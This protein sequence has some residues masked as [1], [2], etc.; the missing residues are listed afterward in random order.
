MRR[1]LCLVALLGPMTPAV[2][3]PKP[4]IAQLP[5]IETFQLDNGLQVAFIAIDTAPV[6]A[7]QLWYRAGVAFTS[8]DQEGIQ[9]LLAIHQK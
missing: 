8:A 3:A 9:T 7:V 1:L 5:K 6:V 2:A 4:A